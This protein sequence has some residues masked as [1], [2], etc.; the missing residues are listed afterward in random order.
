MGIMAA[1][2]KQVIGFIA[3][4]RLPELNTGTKEKDFIRV[5]LAKK[6][7]IFNKGSNVKL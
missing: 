1:F 3:E 7:G 4:T 6:A 2:T 5:K